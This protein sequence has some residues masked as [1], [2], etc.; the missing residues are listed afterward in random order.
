MTS[1]RAAAAKCLAIGAALA[2]QLITAGGAYAQKTIQIDNFTDLQPTDWAYQAIVN[3]VDQ[4]GCISGYSQGVLGGSRA[5][6]RREA[7]ALVN[8]CLDKVSEQTDSVRALQTEFKQELALLQGQTADLEQRVTELE[9]TIFS[10]TTRLRGEA[11]FM[12]GGVSYLG[13]VSANG[14]GKSPVLPRQDALS[15]IYSIRLGFNTSFTG[16][17]LLFTQLRS[18]N[19]ANSPFNTFNPATPWFTSTVPM[20]ALDRAYTPVGGNNVVNIE[21][22][23]YKF[24]LGSQWTANVAPVIMNMGLWGTYPSAYGVRGDYLLDFFSSFGTPGV[25]NKAVGS[26]VALTWRQKPGWTDKTWLAHIHY[27]AIMGNVGGDQGQGIN[28]GIGRNQSMGNI[29]AQFGYQSPQFNLTLGY[30]WGQNG[31]NFLRGT[32]FAAANQWSLPSGTRSNSSS[33]AINSYWMPRERGWIPS[34]SAGWGLN[35]L[36]NP[37]IYSN[38]PGGATVSASQSW[39]A[40]VQWDNLSGIHDVLGIAIGQPTFA[41]ALR[42]GKTPDDGNY[43]FEMFYRYPLSDHINISPGIFYLSRPFGQLTVDSFGLFGAVVQTN[44]V[45]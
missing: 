44:I 31:T 3:L 27:L 13:N 23:Y 39:M 15:M 34:F 30:R 43:A 24:P 32:D 28:G 1:V 41:T 45:F 5:I 19:A 29:A 26:A 33:F 42:N 18:G 9:S 17:D 38:Q 21:R 7:A 40:A 20:A 37:G 11:S 14:I 25:Y 4:Y 8:S 22:I 36:D 10:P 35:V 2:G 12:L 6:S 16:K